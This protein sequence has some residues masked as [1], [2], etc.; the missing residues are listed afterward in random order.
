MSLRFVHLVLFATDLAHKIHVLWEN[1]NALGMNGAKIG[2][3]EEPDQIGLGR[4]LQREKC[5]TIKAQI[6]LEHLCDFTDKTNKWDFAQQQIRILLVST[7]LHERPGP[8]TVSMGLLH[9]TSWPGSL[10]SSPIW[11]RHARPLS[12]LS[13]ASCLFGTCHLFEWTDDYAL[14]N[15]DTFYTRYYSRNGENM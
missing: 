14:F 9:T 11:Q 7:N 13:L 1:G 6:A 12:A 5:I 8:R 10:A 15:C 4:I 3:L 2:I